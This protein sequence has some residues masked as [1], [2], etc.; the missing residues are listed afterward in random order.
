MAMDLQ[1]HVDTL[2][3]SAITPATIPWAALLGWAFGYG[4]PLIAAIVNKTLTVAQVEAAIAALVAIFT[5]P[6]P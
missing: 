6:A 2:N 1:K 5:P 4:F 3:K